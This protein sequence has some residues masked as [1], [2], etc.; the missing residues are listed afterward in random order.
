[1]S[2]AA[3]PLDTD[4]AVGRSIVYAFLTRAFA[5]PSAAHVSALV[6]ELAPTLRRI[7]FA[8]D[9]GVG[10]MVA[11]CLDALDD[12]AHTLTAAHQRL[13]TIIESRD[14]PT[15]ETAYRGR[16]IHQQGE[17]MADV[18]GFY[19]AH[20]LTFGGPQR[21][22]PDHIT[23]ELEFMSFLTAKEAHARDQIGRADAADECRRTQQLFLA[24]HLGAWAPG[25]GQR[26]EAIAATQFYAALGGLLNTWLHADMDHLG[27]SPTEALAKPLPQP[28]PS[29]QT[30]GPDATAWPVPLQQR[31]E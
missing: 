27:T 12:E 31:Q 11:A 1:M 26:V 28:P 3:A 30:C 8:D 18:A 22:R 13:F 23:V 16:D 25:F 19:R 7:E 4:V 24:E 14:C 9:T 10:P 21:E 5:Y 29:D 17:V 2:A 15:Y 6:D 20:G